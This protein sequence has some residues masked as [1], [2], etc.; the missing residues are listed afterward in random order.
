L[1]Q[2]QATVSGAAHL[3]PNHAAGDI[4]G[5]IEYISNQRQGANAGSFLKQMLKTVGREKE[6]AS[7]QVEGYKKE[8]VPG[9]EHLEKKDP[10]RF[11]RLLNSQIS[12]ASQNA[13]N[14]APKTVTGGPNAQPQATQAPAQPKAP[15]SPSGLDESDPRVQEA[16]SHGYTDQQIK[17]YLNGR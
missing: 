10:E 7:K 5:L 11:Y 16:R 6:L 2:G 9:F 8:L 4:A 14:A 17:D 15:V 12:E 1:S 3:V 13:L